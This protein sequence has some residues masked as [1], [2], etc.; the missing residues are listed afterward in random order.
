MFVRLDPDAP[1]P[2]WV[3][4]P[5]LYLDF[6]K[7]TLNDLVGAI[8]TR[9][10]ELGLQP[11]VVTPADR[12]AAIEKRRAFDEET[13]TLL[14][15]SPAEFITATE[16]LLEAI[17]GEA[18]AVAERTGWDFGYGPGAI[19]GGFVVSAH[20]QGVQIVA[21]QQYA[22]TA[23]DAYVELREYDQHLTIAVPGNN[24]FAFDK[25]V[26]VRTTR[27]DIRRLPEIGWCWEVK[28]RT[29]PV[30]AAA[31]LILN[32]LLDRIEKANEKSNRR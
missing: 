30:Q 15:R 23:R 24:Y 26:V 12:A 13:R 20:A 28:G 29:Y 6:T 3:P 4:K 17:R 2:T 16:A 32:V 10:V 25:I 11:Q 14:G 22:N 21:L 9:L 27:L 8:K 1:V 18:T 31:E 5:H 19:I 7:Y